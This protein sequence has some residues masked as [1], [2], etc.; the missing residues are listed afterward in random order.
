[1]FENVYLSTFRF[2]LLVVTEFKAFCKYMVTSLVQLVALWGV[3][4][5]VLWIRDPHQRYN[6]RTCEGHALIRC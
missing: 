6:A 2:I 5:V 4:F 1:M 3:T